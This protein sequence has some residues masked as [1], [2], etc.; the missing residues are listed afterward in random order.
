MNTK[1]TY[2]IDKLSICIQD[3]L[4]SVVYEILCANTIDLMMDNLARIIH[5]KFNCRRA[6]QVIYNADYNNNMIHI[7]QIKSED[8]QDVNITI[9]LQSYQVLILTQ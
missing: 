8:I 6:V 2:D 3:A 5:Q 1:C 9:N 7:L 4:N